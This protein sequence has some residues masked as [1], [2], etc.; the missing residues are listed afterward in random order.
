M[1]ACTLRNAPHL[2]LQKT[3]VWRLWDL[4][5]YIQYKLRLEQHAIKK[6]FLLINK[7]KKEFTMF[8]SA[9]R[10]RICILFFYKKKINVKTC[11]RNTYSD[12]VN[13]CTL[14]FYAHVYK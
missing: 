10:F 3:K 2:V 7:K 8:S 12:H 11:I 9:D 1:F 13:Y 6:N 4:G 5:L 14:Q